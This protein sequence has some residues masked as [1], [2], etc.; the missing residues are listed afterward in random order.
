MLSDP[1]P[2]FR[3]DAFAGLA[4]DYVRYRLPYPT[5][6]LDDLLARADVPKAGARLL[7]LACG[8]GRVA[9]SIAHRFDA[10]WAVDLEPQMVEAGRRAAARLGVAGVQWSVGRVED[11][12]ASADAFDLVTVGDAFHRL[13][14][15]RVAALAFSWLKRGGAFAVIGSD[16]F[17][18]GAA[19]WRRVV[20]EVTREFVGEPARRLGAPN[21]PLAQEIAEEEA[22]L[23]AAGFA[24]IASHETR[25]EHEWSLPELLGNLRSTSVLS[26]RALGERHAA[27]EARLSAGLLAHDP[28]GRYAETVRFGYTLA[29]KP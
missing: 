15:P 29:R 16:S 24:G 22:Q 7:D 27:F 21:A 4:D 1:P 2:N 11:F 26:R 9:L 13:D 3:P 18:D 6:M 25:I 8:T 14:R 12:T 5:S 17:R 20:A 23:R 28:T 10:V 19:P